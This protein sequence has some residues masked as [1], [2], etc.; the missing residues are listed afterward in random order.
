[1]AHF[2]SA[3]PRS[4]PVK[5]F[6]SYAILN[7]FRPSDCCRLMATLLRRLAESDQHG[8][9][10][11]KRSAVSPL[12]PQSWLKAAWFARPRSHKPYH[13][14]L[15]P[16]TLLTG[17][18]DAPRRQSAERRCGAA[19]PAVPRRQ[20]Q[21]QPRCPGPQQNG[22]P[23]IPGNPA[24]RASPPRS[25][26]IAR[27]VSTAAEERCRAQRAQAACS[28]EKIALRMSAEPPPS[29][30]PSRPLPLPPRP[31]PPRRPTGAA[32]GSGWRRE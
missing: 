29:A 11:A 31:V 23:R 18:M 12:F 2:P 10:A 22:R 30:C 25:I 8:Q 3:R 17:R 21:L 6:T 9:L 5:I 19:F 24:P 20:C 14:P 7:M 15:D 16:P 27:T 26:R 13:Q 4:T 1:M 32:Q 28:D